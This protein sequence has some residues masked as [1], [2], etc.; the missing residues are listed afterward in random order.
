[1]CKTKY[2]FKLKDGVYADGMV[3]PKDVH[4]PRH[5]T[6]GRDC[7]SRGIPELKDPRPRTNR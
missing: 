6:G 7:S 2:S 5:N 4:E 3:N 1:M